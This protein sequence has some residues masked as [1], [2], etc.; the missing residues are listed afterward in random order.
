MKPLSLKTER[1]IRLV[2]AGLFGLSLGVII[3]M[4]TLPSGFISK[5]RLVFSAALAVLFAFIYFRFL[6]PYF[7][8]KH[9]E[10]NFRWGIIGI[11]LA[12]LIG[13]IFQKVIAKQSLI[14]P[15]MPKQTLTLTLQSDSL[16]FRP[17]ECELKTLYSKDFIVSGDLER[18]DSGLMILRGYGSTLTWTG[19]PGSTCVFTTASI[20]MKV[21]QLTWEEERTTAV[22]RLSNNPDE[23]TWTVIFPVP[24]TTKLIVAIILIFASLAV[25]L[26]LVCGYMAISDSKSISQEQISRLIPKKGFAVLLVAACVKPYSLTA[27]SL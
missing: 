17:V 2:V 7:I 6:L 21:F 8:R 20:P 5:W 3:W 26:A 12:L 22:G 11:V 23:Y 14:F 1:T 25:V 10:F 13:I 15:F 27:L 18:I 4:V 16:S 19:W 24:N 9:K